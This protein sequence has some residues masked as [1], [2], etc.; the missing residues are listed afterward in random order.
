MF[1]RN[2]I[3]AQRC[4]FNSNNMKVLISVRLIDD[5]LCVADK[6]TNDPVV[7]MTPVMLPHLIGTDDDCPNGIAN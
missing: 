5:G 4:F 1:Q 3:T 6:V 7:L 2:Q